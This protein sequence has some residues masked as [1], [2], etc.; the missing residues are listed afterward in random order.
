MVRTREEDGLAPAATMGVLRLKQNVL[1]ESRAG[2]IATF[3][4]PLGRSGSWELGGDFT[5]QT[6]RFRGDKNLSVGAWGLVTGREDLSGYRERVAVGLKLDYPND[7]WDCYLLYRRIGDGFDPSLGFVPRRG[8]NTYAGGCTFAPR[9]K[10]GFIRQMFHELYPTLT[11]DLGGRWESWEVWVGPVNW[12]LESGDR[13]EVG[14]VPLGERLAEPFEIA[15]GVSVP[16]GSYDALRYRVEVETAAKRRL[17][18]E[19]EW[20]FGG[21]YSGTLDQFE[22]AAT[23]TPSP[24]VTFLASVEHSV[25][26]LDEGDF[27]LTLVSAKLRL[28]LSPDLQF[29]SFVQYDTEDRSFG[30]NTRLRWSFD[31]RG[32]LFLIYNHNLRQLESS[33]R[34]D[35]S[36]LLVKV[37]YTFRK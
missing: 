16:A 2:F 1:A 17:A 4:D 9:P 11:T 22:L 7:L 20:A 35:A 5:Y 10:G 30:S 6:S 8:I 23:W 29:N 27:D 34:K 21:F 33:W 12:L 14:L 24:L 32:D 31:P 18:L 36:Q 3:G 28:N 25:G 15:E 13:V 19:A 26:R 37:Q